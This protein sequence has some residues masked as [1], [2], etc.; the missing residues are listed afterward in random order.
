MTGDSASVGTKSPIDPISSD[1]GRPGHD[2][3]STPQPLSIGRAIAEIRREFP[4][5]RHSTLRYLEREDLIHPVRTPGGHRLFSP[6]E[7]QRVL[8][9]RRWQSQGQSLEDV[10]ERLATWSPTIDPDV[11]ATTMF[12]LMVRARF[13]D[14]RQRFIDADTA[15]ASM[16]TLLGPVL[17]VT[18]QRVGDQWEQGKLQVSREKEI[19]NVA[20]DL[21]AELTARHPPPARN[22][23]HVVAAAI[24]GETHDLGLRVV[25]ALLNSMGYHVHLLGADVRIDHIAEA[26]TAWRPVGVLLSARIDAHRAT[27][28]ETVDALRV[29]DASVTVIVGGALADRYADTLRDH[30]AVPVTGSGTDL[31]T[32]ME[33]LTEILA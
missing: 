25:G 17:G 24:A 27:L 12:E 31:D 4:D 10:R 1:T 5:V 19:S 15:G 33:Q 16:A 13:D 20:R 2:Q 11:L 14:A 7:I 3:D 30:G 21:V 32:M 23:K 18:M 22:G 6:E 9:I 8:Q 29:G 26:M 28:L